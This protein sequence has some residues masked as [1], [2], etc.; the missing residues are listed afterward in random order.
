Q[1]KGECWL[2][3]GT[4][5]LPGKDGHKLWKSDWRRD[6]RNGS[7]MRVKLSKSA[8]GKTWTFQ[9]DDRRNL[10]PNN[11]VATSI[12]FYDDNGNESNELRAWIDY[13]NGRLLEPGAHTK[14]LVGKWVDEVTDANY[15]RKIMATF[16][17]DD[18]YLIEGNFNSDKKQGI[19]NE[20]GTWKVVNG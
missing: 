5:V 3:S 7:F 6:E 17:D 14:V 9:I 15:S 16:K 2:I 20:K 13:A 18:T 12:V 8:Q 11:Y 4:S 19:I 10:P 1:E